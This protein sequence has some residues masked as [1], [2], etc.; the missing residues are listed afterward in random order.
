M[1]TQFL[2]RAK[3]L[4]SFLLI[5]L[6]LSVSAYTEKNILQ[7]K[8]DIETLKSELLYNHKWVPEPRYSNRQAWDSLV[9]DSR[10]QMI[11]SGEKNLTLT[12]DVIT[13]KDYLEYE[14]TGNRKIM[15]T[16]L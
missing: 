8:A 6:T 14:R 9:A 10:A 1:K 2:S 5:S 4:L 13:A 3:L 11:R 7:R 15:E 16:P 12:W